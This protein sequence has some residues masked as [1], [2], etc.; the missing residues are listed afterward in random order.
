MLFSCSICCCWWRPEHHIMFNKR[1]KLAAT[2]KS[3]L[4]HLCL[5]GTFGTHVLLLPSSKPIELGLTPPPRKTITACRPVTSTTHRYT[6]WNGHQVPDSF[7]R[8]T[9]LRS[10]R[11]EENPSLRGPIPAP[12]ASRQGCA[13][14]A[15]ELVMEDTEATMLGSKLGGW[16]LMPRKARQQAKQHLY[17]IRDRL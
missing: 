8:L 1:G 4:F 2:E 15:D 13:V 7:S 6:T 11:L 5:R 17:Q 9:E 10:L 16:F 12:L 3:S 14:R